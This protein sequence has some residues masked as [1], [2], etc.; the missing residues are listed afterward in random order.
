MTALGL[1]RGVARVLAR[2]ERVWARE[3]DLAPARAEKAL[4]AELARESGLASATAREQG[5]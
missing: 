2:T 1:V 4:A 3:R 5:P